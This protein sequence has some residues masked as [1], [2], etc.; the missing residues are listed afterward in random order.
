MK[1]IFEA[2]TSLRLASLMLGEAGRGILIMHFVERKPR[3]SG[4]S[5]VPATFDCGGIMSLH[6]TES[7]SGEFR[8]GGLNLSHYNLA[9]YC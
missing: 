3:R 1:K 6:P 5:N 9:G 4:T 2:P 8:E 7:D